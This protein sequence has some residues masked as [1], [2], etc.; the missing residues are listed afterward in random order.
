MRVEL[1]SWMRENAKYVALWIFM[2][3]VLLG[4]VIREIGIYTLA[5]IIPF[6][7]PF[8]I[9]MVKMAKELRK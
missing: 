4:L 3:L 5:I 8:I 1:R 7:P 9:A 6:L 2:G